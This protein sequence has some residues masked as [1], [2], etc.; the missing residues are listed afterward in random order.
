[1]KVL[2]TTCG[3][4]AIGACM[5]LV[6]PATSEIDLI[7]GY[8]KWKSATSRPADMS[9]SMALSCKG[10]DSWDQ[11]GNPHVPKVFAVYVNK[12]GEEAMFKKDLAFFPDGTVIVK[13]KYNRADFKA[14]SGTDYLFLKNSDL[15]GKKPELLTVMSKNA[16]KWS[17]FAV[18]SDGKLQVGDTSACRQCHAHRRETDFV[19]RNYVDVKGLKLEK[20]GD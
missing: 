4:L 2:L 3:V 19:F 17:Y 1:M 8:K 9:P 15:K 18:G 6:K 11:T 10:P 12:V 13:E 16:G 7:K 14:K 20:S 5:A